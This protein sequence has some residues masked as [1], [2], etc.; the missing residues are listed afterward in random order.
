MASETFSVL[1]ENRFGVLARVAG[2]F[3]GRGYN[4]DSLTV[5]P[6]QDT[7]YS[8]M[9][10]VTHGDAVILEQIEKQL[11]KLIEVVRV[12]RLT[13]GAF[14][15]RELELLKLRTEDESA[16][17]ELMQLCSSYGAHVIDVQEK[18]LVIQLTDL[19]EKIDEF[20]TLVR[21]FGIVELARTGSVALS[22]A[23]TADAPPPPLRK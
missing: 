21:S 14:V 9:T 1:V 10:I 6:T 12:T 17:R 4:I 7:Q 16:R 20:M 3:C 23:D 13:A 2:L 18:S 22:R 11:N 19:P 8:R 15:V 5:S